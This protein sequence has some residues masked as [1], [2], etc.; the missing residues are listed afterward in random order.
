V[1]IFHALSLKQ[2]F[3]YVLTIIDNLF[4][5]ALVIDQI[6]AF[7]PLLLTISCKD[8]LWPDIRRLSSGTEKPR[9]NIGP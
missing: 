9:I 1:F 6:F 8:R 7:F 5:A 4:D 3:R 2:K